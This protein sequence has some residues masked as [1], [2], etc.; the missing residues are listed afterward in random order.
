MIVVCD[1]PLSNRYH[2]ITFRPFPSQPGGL[3][4]KPGHDYYFITLPTIPSQ[5]PVLC[6][7]HHMKV[8][9]KIFDNRKPLLVTPTTTTTFTT[10]I[11][12]PI[13]TTT[14]TTITTS[15]STTTATTS[16]TT[17]TTTPA[18]TSSRINLIWYD[19]TAAY[20]SRTPDSYKKIDLNLCDN[21]I[22]YKKEKCYKVVSKRVTKTQ[23]LQECLTLDPKASLITI[24]SK[25]EQEFITNFIANYSSITDKVWTG[26]NNSNV[27]SYSNWV[28][29]TPYEYSTRIY[30]SY[31]GNR[32]VSI[33]FCVQMSV[34]VNFMGKWYSEP[35]GRRALVVCQK[36]Q[37]W[38]MNIV[39]TALENLT[40]IVNAQQNIINLL[41]RER[42]TNVN[43]MAANRLNDKSTGKQN[44]P[45]NTVN[46]EQNDY[47]Y[48]GD[49]GATT[50][51]IPIGFIY[52]QLPNQSEPRHLWPLTTWADVTKEYSGL[53]FRAEGGDSGVFGQIQPANYS[54]RK[55]FATGA[56]TGTD[57]ALN[58]IPKEQLY[59]V[60][61]GQ[62]NGMQALN[63][64]LIYTTKGE[65]RPINTAIK[66]WK[67]IA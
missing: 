43:S 54:T 4:F 10:T 34:N 46:T 29:D 36:R 47:F 40:Q 51:A 26:M 52:T 24:S 49:L 12:T 50:F 25:E 45:N 22:T 2:R 35:C 64:I 67:R 20:P 9:F 65:N 16:T 37:E 61:E 48:Q 58:G 23:A 28:D 17:S 53:F 5:P 11:A 60:R 44:N 42:N 27:H 6:K 8:M 1:K 62:W 32:M 3:E 56:E 38:T 41:L 14:S 30:D 59:D 21:W 66:L 19:E 39:S 57:G 13:T 7:S 18:T 31:Q 33:G 55:V 63:K 15:T